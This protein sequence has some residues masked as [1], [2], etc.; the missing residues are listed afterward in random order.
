MSKKYT[1]YSNTIIYKIVCRDPNIKDL[2][3]GHTTNFVNRK[4][5]HKNNSINDKSKLYEVIR[6]NGGWEN[7]NME[8][9][10]FF[11]CRDLYEAR[12]KEQEYFISLNATLNSVEPMANSTVK[13]T[14][15]CKKCD[16]I[17]NDLQLLEKHKEDCIKE[18]RKFNCE[19]C[20]YSSNKKSNL[21]KHLKTNKHKILIITNIN[22]NNSE[23]FCLK[24]N[25]NYRS[26]VGLWK[27]KKK[28]N[29]E[30][31]N[32][33]EETNKESINTNNIIKVI[34]KENKDFKNMIMDLVINNTELHKEIIEMYKK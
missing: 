25:K 21:D 30:E 13:E 2:Y 18:K 3:V 32:N 29:G 11:N 5:S 1:D 27:H 23:L 8:I 28:C 16:I 31:T 33:N 4:L 17:F 15:N 22:K 6:K 34:L 7:W 19:R 10:N 24:C 9:V 20:N 14:F 12:L 26:R